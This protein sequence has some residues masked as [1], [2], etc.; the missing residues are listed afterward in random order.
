MGDLVLIIDLVLWVNF[1]KWVLFWL[2][3]CMW[4]LVFMCFLDIWT[5]FCFSGLGIRIER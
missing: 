3:L 5:Y 4:D 2:V 1:L